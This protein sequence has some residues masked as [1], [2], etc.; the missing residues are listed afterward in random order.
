[1][2]RAIFITAR[3]ASTRLPQ[4]AS[5][6]VYG[7]TT[8]IEHV[9][10]RAK[11]SLKNECIILCTTNRSED[12]LLCDVAEQHNINVFRGS[13]E[14]KLQRWLEATKEYEIDFFTTM[15]G[16]DPFCIPEFL[17]NSLDQIVNN[18]VDFIDRPDIISGLFT[19]TIATKALQKV[20]EIKDSTNTEMMWTYFKDTGLFKLQTL[21][22]VS[23]NFLRNDIRLTLDY[24]EDYKLFKILF[25][26][27]PGDENI[28]VIKVIRFLDE[29]PQL[30]KI[31]LFRQSEFLENQKNNTTLKLKMP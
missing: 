11:A 16:D 5:L 4:K 26:S 27:I 19:Y 8:L 6:V 18:C 15:D 2:R 25:E 9:I 20:C 7:D 1:M 10:K 24:L 29:N 22:N 14:D 17:D 30:K 31:N 13:T 28:D 23:L 21:D 12:S 3:M